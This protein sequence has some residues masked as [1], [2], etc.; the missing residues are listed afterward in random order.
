VLSPFKSD[1]FGVHALNARLR[2]AL[3]FDTVAPRVG[4]VVMCIENGAGDG[5]GFRLLNGMRLMVVDFDR[6]SLV[7]H[8][9]SSGE[10]KS[11]P[12]RPHAHGPAETIVWGRAATVHKYQGSE[13]AAVIMVIP[14]DALRLIE[15]EP[16]IFDAANFYTGVSRAKK[17]VAIMGA[18]DQL[19]ALLKLG[20]RRRITTLE[21]ALREAR[22][23]YPDHRT[24]VWGAAGVIRMSEPTTKNPRG[25]FLD[26]PL[27]WLGH[28]DKRALTLVEMLDWLTAL[29]EEYGV[30]ATFIS[31]GI[32][33]DVTMIL[34]AVADYMPTLAY[35]K[36]YEI[37]KKE[38]LGSDGAIKVKGHV[39]VGDYAIDWIKG[40]RLVI[41][42]FRDP[43]NP[44][45]G[46]IRRIT[47]YDLHGFYQSSFVKVMKSLEKLGLA[48][49][50]E[51]AAIERDK[52]RRQN[53]DQ[54]P[55]SEVKPYTEL[56]LRKL[57][58]AAIKLRDG[59]DYMGIRLGSW[60]GA[61]AAAAAL[62][63]ARGVS[64]HYAGWVNKRDPSP[65]QLIA[66][67]AYYGGH[68]E[69]LKQGYARDGAFVYDLKSAYP[70]EMQ[71]LP[72]MINGHV[73]HWSITDHRTGLDWGEVETSSKISAFFIRWRLPVFYVDR[74][75]GEVRG[76]PFFPLPYRLKGGGI[77]FCSEGSGW[78]MRDE[79][80]AAKRYLETFAELGLPG[81]GADGLPCD[82]APEVA[83]KIA[84]CLGFKR[85]PRRA[86]DHGLNLLITEA[87]FFEA[88]DT[89][90]RPYAFI[91]E[92][93]DERARLRRE[94]PGNVPEQN[95]KLSLN[96]LSG[97]AAQSVGGN[98][99]APPR[100]A[101]PWYAAA[102]TAGTRRR[103]MEAALQNPHVIVQFST[104]GVVS[105]AP[106]DLDI[107]E[108]L[109]QWEA[110]RVAPGTPSVF[111]QSGLYTYRTTTSFR[112]SRRA[113]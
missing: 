67:A 60:S 89:Q 13:A 37:C 94:E 4:E 27:H 28:D 78:Y 24:F 66:H 103:V 93:Y 50:E 14:P 96:S 90:K 6:K 65:E 61:G 29:P 46:F 76:V 35:R 106:L 38:R 12:Y 73:R 22:H 79:A 75:S 109:G 80:I 26:L 77:L 110:K 33:Y 11:V 47:V 8:H 55:L 5:D 2:A 48:T 42:K 57:S 82:I 52:A 44:K 7:L 56:E 41:K 59:F 97:K 107:G 84:P 72:S 34:Q 95:I 68:I 108:G 40:K 83:K 113:A 20:T 23:G 25:E 111:L 74:S 63:Y 91:P 70:A 105:L 21:R 9:I 39:F 58:L 64:E 69:L 112:P 85:L 86:K 62:I 31:F 87:A 49:A 36:V 102:T 98:E 92:L 88:D 16:H 43:A 100:T 17:R 15:K 53:F 51:V 54:V 19:P 1:D 10:T 71:H 45:A 101:C 99:T 3:G 32:D 18:L 81:V 104:D 30:P